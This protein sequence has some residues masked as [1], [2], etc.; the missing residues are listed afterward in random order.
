MV[1]LLCTEASLPYV[2]VSSSVVLRIDDRLDIQVEFCVCENGHHPCW[3]IQK[4]V[5]VMALEAMDEQE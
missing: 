2:E 3:E 5:M 4:G 1:L